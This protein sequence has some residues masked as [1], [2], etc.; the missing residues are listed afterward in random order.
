MCRTDE[1]LKAQS[2]VLSRGAVFMDDFADWIESNWHVFEAFSN[3]ADQT[4]DA[5]WKHYSARTIMEVIR[6]RSNIREVSG[7]YKIN[8]NKIPDCAR[9]YMLM[10]QDRRGMFEFRINDFRLAA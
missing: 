3:A 8:N 10:N 1:M 9:L 6:H 5:G 4:W 7:S 2:M